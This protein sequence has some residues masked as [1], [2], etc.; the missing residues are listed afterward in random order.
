MMVF[1]ELLIFSESGLF[2]RINAHDFDYPMRD[3]DANLRLINT[4]G[5]VFVAM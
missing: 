2:I 3:E 4:L 1:K 5:S